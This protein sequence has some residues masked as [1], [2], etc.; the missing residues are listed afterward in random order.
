[1]LKPIRMKVTPEVII[2]A[3]RK[4]SKKD[5]KSFLNHI[6]PYSFEMFMHK[7]ILSK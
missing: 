7:E 4:M 1:M 6:P 5:Q 2:E 3:I